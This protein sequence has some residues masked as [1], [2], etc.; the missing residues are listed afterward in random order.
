LGYLWNASVRR[1]D[2]RLES[3]AQEAGEALEREVLETPDAPLNLAAAEAVAEWPSNDDSFAIL[4]DHRR[5]MAAADRAHA[6]DSVMAHATRT[7]KPGRFVF[8]RNNEDYR[9][10]ATSP[11]TVTR[12]GQTWRYSVVAY[13]TTEGIEHD[14]EVLLGV[15]ALI[16]R[17]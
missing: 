2:A 6:V 17:I 9:A 12:N 16:A 4:D 5:L 8:F 3:V 11:S 14:V 1:L 7:A 10:V 15:I 13:H